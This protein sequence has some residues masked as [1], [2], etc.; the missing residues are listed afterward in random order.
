[1]EPQ[2]T[3][4]ESDFL[5]DPAGEPQ[6]TSDQVESCGRGRKARRRAS[7]FAVRGIAGWV[8]FSE[9]L[10]YTTTYTLSFGVC[11]PV[12]LACRCIP[13]NNPLVQGLIAGASDASTQVDVLFARRASANTL[14]TESLEDELVAEAGAGALAPS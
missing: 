1:M 2:K 8:T 5:T 14:V 10:V 6:A 9:R 12:L 4:P 3:S 13:Q 7:A 11:F